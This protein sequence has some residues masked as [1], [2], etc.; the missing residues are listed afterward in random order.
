MIQALAGA[1]P[2]ALP[3]VEWNRKDVRQSWESSGT[4]LGLPA[5]STGTSVKQLKDRSCSSATISPSSWQV[6][7]LAGLFRDKVYDPDLI[8]SP[9]L[10][11]R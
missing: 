1:L 5:S 6:T 11:R 2:S 8:G 3:Y 10:E 7:A 4:F 9:P